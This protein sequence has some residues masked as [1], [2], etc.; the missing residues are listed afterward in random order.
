MQIRSLKVNLWRCPG[1]STTL[2]EGIP[3]HSSAPSKVCLTSSIIAPSWYQT[4]YDLDQ[5]CSAASGVLEQMLAFD[6]DAAGDL[7]ETHLDAA[8]DVLRSEG[9]LVSYTSWTQPRRSFAED[10]MLPYILDILHLQRASFSV[11]SL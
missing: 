2:A 1:A 10:D 3:T 5:I 4:K 9:C 6:S 11:A 7:L 8:I